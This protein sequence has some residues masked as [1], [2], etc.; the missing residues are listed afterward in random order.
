MCGIINN[1]KQ[2]QIVLLQ[3]NPASRH[4]NINENVQSYQPVFDILTSGSGHASCLA[5]TVNFVVDR[6]IV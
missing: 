5:W 3:Y 2:L 4:I 6:M 1:C